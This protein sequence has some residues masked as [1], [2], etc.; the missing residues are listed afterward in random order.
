MSIKIVSERTKFGLNGAIKAGH[1]PGKCPLGYYRDKD[2]TLKIDNST[3]DIVVRIFEMYLEG[4]SYQTIV[5]ILN[6]EKVLYPEVKHWIDSSINR[7]IN[8]KIYI[9]VIM[10][11]TNMI[12]IEKQNYLWMLY[13]LL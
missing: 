7:I 10:K 4:K 1:I 3:K 6:K 11:D 9:W 13:L 2:K 12:M 8:N 5:N